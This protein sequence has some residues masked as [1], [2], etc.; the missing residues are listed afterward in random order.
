MLRVGPWNR[1]ALTIQWLKPQYAIDFDPALQ[2]PT[3]MPLQYGLVISKKV[4]APQEHSSSDVLSPKS[5]SA[6]F[7]DVC[8]KEVA[9]ADIVQCLTS[10]CRMNSHIECLATHFLK[11]D[12]DHVLPLEGSCPVCRQEFLWADVIRKLKGCYQNSNLTLHDTTLN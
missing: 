1:L 2:P 8:S 7:C 9:G 10:D 4:S 11:S 6:V 12:P 3:H 5:L